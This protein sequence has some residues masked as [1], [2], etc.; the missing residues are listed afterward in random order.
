M[1]EEELDKRIDM[2]KNSYQKSTSQ[3]SLIKELSNLK[4]GKDTTELFISKVSDIRMKMKNAND[5]IGDEQFISKIIEEMP[6]FMSLLQTEYR[7]KGWRNEAIKYDEL[8][9]VTINA[10]RELLEQKK[11][12]ETSRDRHDTLYFTKTRKCSI[13][14]S[15]AH[16]RA[17]CPRNSNNNSNQSNNNYQNYYQG[18]RNNYNPRRRSRYHQVMGRYQGQGDNSANS[19]TNQANQYQQNSPGSSTSNI[20]VQNNNIQSQTQPQPQNNHQNERSAN[21]NDN[22]NTHRNQQRS[23]NDYQI[24]SNGSNLHYISTYEN[25]SYCVIQEQSKSEI[26]YLDN[27][28]QRH[29]VN[30]LH[31]FSEYTPFEQPVKVTGAGIGNALGVGKVP[32]VTRIRNKEIGFNLKD[33]YYMPNMKVNIVSQIQCENNGIKF[34]L[35]E[36]SEHYYTYGY[37]KNE[38][39]MVSRRLKGT[40]NHYQLNMHFKESNVFL[41]DVEWHHILGHANYLRIDKTAD[42]VI[43]MNLTKTSNRNKTCISCIKAKSKRRSYNHHLLKSTIPGKV[44][45]TDICNLLRRSLSGNHYFIVFVDECSRYVR[46]YFMNKIDAFSV[47]EFNLPIVL[48][49]LPHPSQTK[50][51]FLFLIIYYVYLII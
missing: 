51:M 10:Y 49:V 30:Q 31:R 1:R 7:S 47:N 16:L 2:L 9:T 12:K 48:Y 45:R 17:T 4:W 23:N 18:N 6:R 42:Q 19:Q 21:Q 35:S 37:V 34:E 41:L 13:C 29:I 40:N 50:D 44:I 22:F 3:L 46:V 20:P 15:I 32:V 38:P 27:C 8:V 25:S 14:N 28:S 11:D 26:F 33:V 36:S 39:I 5:K 24:N 43:G